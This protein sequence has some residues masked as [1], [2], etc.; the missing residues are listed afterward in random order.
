MI[1]AHPSAEPSRLTLIE[2]SRSA[3]VDSHRNRE[4][5]S[6]MSYT[7][8][9]STQPD[10]YSQAES[11]M[12]LWSGYSYRWNDAPCSDAANRNR[13]LSDI[14]RRDARGHCFSAGEKN[15]L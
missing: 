15:M 8:W 1:K 11:C 13:I 5:V 7:N 4:T 14:E 12:H 6:Q 2:S 10:F 9:Y 3:R